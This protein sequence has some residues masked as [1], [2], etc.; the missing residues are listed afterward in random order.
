MSKTK[1]TTKYQALCEAYQIGIDQCDLYRKEC[2][3]FVHDMKNH[4]MEGLSCRET[5]IFMFSPSGN[6]T[7]NSQT[8]QGDALDT[9][10][11]ENGM[12]GIGFAINVNGDQLE[13]RFF[14]FILMFKKVD[15][16]FIF[17]VDDNR[18]F[19]NNPEDLSKFCDY[20]YEIAHKNLSNRLQN[21]LQSPNAENKPIG[22]RV[23]SDGK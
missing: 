18:D 21:F 3:E 14:T 5:K 12:A 1:K 20:L 6:F 11:S 4:I 19:K 8:L 2:Q 23:G 16:D 9:E 22:F 15:D 7:F 13:E 17:N 10:F